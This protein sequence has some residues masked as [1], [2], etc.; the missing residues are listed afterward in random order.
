MKSQAFREV[1]VQEISFLIVFKKWG[2]ADLVF[3]HKTVPYSNY[4]STQLFEILVSSGHINEFF[5]S[6]SKT[7]V[8]IKESRSKKIGIAATDWSSPD[9]E[10]LE[11]LS[12]PVFA[13]DDVDDN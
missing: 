2:G 10:D 1:T 7:Y 12:Q 13:K 5:N 9:V 6:Y 8:W 3:S 11:S 4:T